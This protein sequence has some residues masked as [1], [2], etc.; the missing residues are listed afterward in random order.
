MPV[1][2]LPAAKALMIGFDSAI[3]FGAL[4]LAFKL[5]VGGPILSDGLFAW[6]REFAPYAGIAIA[7][8]PI[9]LG[10]LA[11]YGAYRLKGPFSAI[12]EFLRITRAVLLG[13]LA[14]ITFT[15]L[16]RGGFEYREF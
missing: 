9:R 16:F 3:A 4:A 10:F 11:Y 15:F 14:I 7:A 8:I 1:W 2:V 12:G 13:S 6:S 5:R